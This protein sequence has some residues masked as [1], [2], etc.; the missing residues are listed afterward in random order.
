MGFGCRPHST[1]QP[2]RQHCSSSHEPF[3]SRR[4]EAMISAREKVSLLTPTPT[5]T[6]K[7]HG[8]MT[9]ARGRIW[10]DCVFLVNRAGRSVRRSQ[11][12]T[13]RARFLGCDAMRILQ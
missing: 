2:L 13:R 6:E 10:T 5:K 4:E 7:D 8:E 11:R 1:F 9:V 3:W 12:Q